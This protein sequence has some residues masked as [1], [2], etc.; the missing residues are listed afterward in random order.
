MFWTIKSVPEKSLAVKA[1]LIG[2]CIIVTIIY[3]VK[4]KSTPIKEP[5]MVSVAIVEF[6]SFVQVCQIPLATVMAIRVL[7]SNPLGGHPKI[8]ILLLVLLIVPPMIIDEPSITY[9]VSE[10][11]L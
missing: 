7:S 3:P 2:I 4:D 8:R 10:L 9:V 5:I 6:S 11:A 1:I